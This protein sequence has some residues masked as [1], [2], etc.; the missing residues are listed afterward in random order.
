[1]TYF[2]EDLTKAGFNLKDAEVVRIIQKYQE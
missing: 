2:N 1:M